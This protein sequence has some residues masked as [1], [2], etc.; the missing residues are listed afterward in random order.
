MSLKFFHIK[1]I[2]FFYLKSRQFIN[3]LG[4]ISKNIMLHKIRCC[5][6]N[7][8]SHFLIKKFYKKISIEPEHVSSFAIKLDNKHIKSPN[9]HII[10]GFY[11]NS[12][13]YLN[14]F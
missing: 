13:S 1:L 11:K 8:T 2:F 9:K 12:F 3:L 6:S 4:K 10:K 14:S 7:T 5:F